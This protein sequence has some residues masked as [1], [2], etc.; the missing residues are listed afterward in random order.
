VLDGLMAKEAAVLSSFSVK[1]PHADCGWIDSLL[2][3]IVRGG[4]DAEIASMQRA[5]FAVRNVG[6]TGRSAYA[7]MK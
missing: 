4:S 3:S 5:W 7:V 6:A 1:C 2:P